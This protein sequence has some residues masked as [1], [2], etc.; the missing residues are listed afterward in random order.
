MDL[1]DL[2]TCFFAAVLWVAL[3]HIRSLKKSIDTLQKN[4]IDPPPPKTPDCRN[5][6]FYKGGKI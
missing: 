5:C 4:S 1:K 6:P 2:I 3:N